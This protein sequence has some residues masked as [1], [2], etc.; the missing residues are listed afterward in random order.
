MKRYKQICLCVSL[1]IY[2]TKRHSS[3][4]KK[5]LTNKISEMF[6]FLFIDNTKVISAWENAKSKTLLSFCQN[7]MFLMTWFAFCFSSEVETSSRTCLSSFRQ[8]WLLNFSTFCQQASHP[9]D[10]LSFVQQSRLLWQPAG[11]TFQ[12]TEV[13][14]HFLNQRDLTSVS[15]GLHS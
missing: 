1:L 7:F 15:P 10:R 8:F 13:S 14:R 9:A 3:I 12:H 5:S 6:F 4:C 11:W 2:L